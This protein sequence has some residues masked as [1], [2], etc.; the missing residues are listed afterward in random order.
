MKIDRI[1]YVL[2]V[3]KWKS[4]TVAAQNLHITQSAISQSITAVE[5]ELGNK[6]FIRSRKGIELTAFGIKIIEKAKHLML[7][8]DGLMEVANSWGDELYGH[9]KVATIPGTMPILI[10]VVT[11]LK[12]EHPNVHI[13]I[14]E[15]GSQEIVR[16]VLNN[17]CDIGL[18]NIY[19]DTKHHE[20]LT[21]ETLFNG[22]IKV[23]F[24]N[25]S[26]LAFKKSLLPQD[27]LN[28]TFVI[29]D[30]EPINWF[31]RNFEEHHGNLHILFKTNNTDAIRTALKNEIG[32]TFAL[33]YSLE[34]EPTIL[35]GETNARYLENVDSTLIKFCLIQHKKQKSSPIAQAFLE[36]FKLEIRHCKY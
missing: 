25:N 8:Y 5:E 15:K 2:E 19:K 7:T 24:N 36:K 16:D 14:V 12:K 21:V 11:L 31:I 13:Q 17:H 29:Y 18:I 4:I 26:I 34:Y 10:N 32:I 1:Q 23:C 33:D 28:Q 9:L 35:N 3:A 22:R 20:D 27:F 30:D 6:I